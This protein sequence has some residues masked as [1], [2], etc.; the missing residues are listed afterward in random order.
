MA[1]TDSK[2]PKLRSTRP[3]NERQP[4]ASNGRAEILA[5]G[6][7]R[8]MRRNAVRL[9]PAASQATNSGWPSASLVVDAAKCR[10]GVPPLVVVNAQKAARCRFYDDAANLM[11]SSCRIR[12]K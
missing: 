3:D 8:S 10:S 2:S 12:D 9:P 4:I 1:A 7:M 6:A 11:L 5:V